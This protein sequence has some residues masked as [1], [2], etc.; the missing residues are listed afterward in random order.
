MDY[1]RE[2]EAWK[3]FKYFL[4]VLC[5]IAALNK[6]PLKYAFGKARFYAKPLH[7]QL[8]LNNVNI[9]LYICTYIVYL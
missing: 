6:H 4:Q 8:D 3:L 2:A 5:F 9:I 1:Y 7:N